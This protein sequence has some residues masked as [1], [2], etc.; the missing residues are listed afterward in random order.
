[1]ANVFIVDND[2]D[3]AEL[4]KE[5]FESAGH[6]I[7]VGHTGAGPLPDCLL[8]EATADA[9]QYRSVVKG[10]LPRLL[11]ALVAIAKDTEIGERGGELQRVPVGE[12]G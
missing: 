12:G 11:V 2:S 6:Q 1:M 10:C 9:P 4:S 3:I 8:L 5:L 7:R